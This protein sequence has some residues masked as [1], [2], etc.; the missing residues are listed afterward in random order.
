MDREVTDDTSKGPENVFWDVDHAPPSGTYWVCVTTA[1]FAAGSDTTPLDVSVLVRKD[2]A[3]KTTLKKT[4]STFGSA[5]ECTPSA[6]TFVGSVDLP[7]VSPVDA[8]AADSGTT[9]AGPKD[10]GATDSGNGGGAN[11]CG[12]EGDGG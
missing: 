7:G 10:A 2:G 11:D 1:S 5:P 6:P 4:F 9:D 8:G 3:E 12:V